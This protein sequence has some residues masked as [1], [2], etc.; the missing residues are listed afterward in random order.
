MSSYSLREGGLF[1]KKRHRKT[2]LEG[3]FP[4]SETNV[5]N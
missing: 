3:G 5:T 2:Q 1:N 4:A